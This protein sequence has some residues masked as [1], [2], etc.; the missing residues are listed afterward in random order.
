MAC[1]VLLYQ[2]EAYQCQSHLQFEL[3]E[4]RRFKT[5]ILGRDCYDSDALIDMIYYKVVLS[6]LFSSDADSNCRLSEQFTYLLS[7]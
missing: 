4:V 1:V 6:D 3:R 5:T 2:L 7:L